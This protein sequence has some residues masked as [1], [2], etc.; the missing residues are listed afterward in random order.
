MPKKEN[1]LWETAKFVARVAILT[2]V[3]AVI[4]QLAADKPEWGVWLGIAA[5]IFDKL[6]HEDKT[7]PAKGLLPF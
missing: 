4:A 1:P 6:I 3:P 5:V 2:S 7:I